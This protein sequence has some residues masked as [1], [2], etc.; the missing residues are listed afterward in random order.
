MIGAVLIPVPAGVPGIGKVLVGFIVCALGFALPLIARIMRATPAE[1]GHYVDGLDPG[2]SL[3]DLIVLAGS[4]ASLAGV[5]LMLIGSAATPQAKAVQ[6]AIT[7]GA[8]FSAWLLV[9]TMFAL[10]YARHW[11]NAEEG[12]IDFHMT[13]PPSYS[14]F[15][16][17]AFAI[18]VSF[19][20]SD[21]DLCTTRVR[22]IALTHSWLSYLF[23][24]VVIAATINLVA[25]LAP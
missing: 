21:T 14:D 25:G 4:L 12:C 8:V 10:R 18:G 3:T 13:Q 17:T 23:G 7:L 1:T 9:H 22:R 6:A 2:P 5:A 19:A 15:L 16:Y 20:V 11:F 24:T